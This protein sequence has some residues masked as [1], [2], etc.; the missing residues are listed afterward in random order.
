MQA[1]S[2]DDALLDWV[3][4]RASMCRRV[5]SVCTGAFI[6][7]AA[8]LLDGRR[9]TTH[10]S[11]C[12]E[13]AAAFPS[14]RVEQDPICINDGNVW[15]SAGVIAGI[16]M[17]LA[18]M[19]ADLGRPI[20]TAVARYLVIVAKRPRARLS[21]AP[22]WRWLVRMRSTTGCGITCEGIWQCRRWRSKRA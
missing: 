10:W 4:Q 6:L 19:E 2:R 21:S 16:D 17:A 20:A 12:V 3:G 13:L 14:V 8:G 5:S 15:T 1:A 11:R 22:G 9:A 18:L 7:A